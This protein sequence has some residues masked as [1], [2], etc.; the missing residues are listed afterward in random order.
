MF[1]FLCARDSASASVLS[2]PAICSTFMV[3]LNLAEHS[4]T[5]LAIASIIGHLALPYVKVAT[6]EILSH[7]TSTTL[8]SNNGANRRIPTNVFI[9]SKCEMLKLRCIIHSGYLV[10]KLNGE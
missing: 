6:A 8:C 10:R 2:A 5:A 9:S 4:Q 7:F 1:L 3:K